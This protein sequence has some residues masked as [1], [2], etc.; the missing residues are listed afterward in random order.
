MS[1]FSLIFVTICA[2]L[3]KAERTVKTNILYCI[4]GIYGGLRDAQSHS[5]DDFTGD[6][7]APHVIQMHDGKHLVST[8][9]ATN[10]IRE[11]ID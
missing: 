9:Q 1:C 3:T 11:Q 2:F 6:F 4:S 8:W 10:P 5:L 7:T